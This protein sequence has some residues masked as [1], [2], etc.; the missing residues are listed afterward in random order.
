MTWIQIRLNV[1]VVT[2]VMISSPSSLRAQD[3]LQ[4]QKDACAKNTAMTWNSEMNRCVGK[5]QTRSERHEAQDC[6]KLEDVNAR[7]ACHMDV[8]TKKAGVTSDPEQAGSKVSSLQ[9]RSAMINT[10][11]TIVSL[12]NMFASKKAGSACMS[13]SIMGITAM[14]GLAT[15]IY[16]KI[17]TKKKLGALKD[18]FQ[19]ELKDSAYN[20]QVKALAFLKEEQEVVQKIA[21]MEK[22][23]QMLLML[24]YGAAA[25]AAGYESFTNADC[26]KKEPDKAPAPP[27]EGA[28]TVAETATPGASGAAPADPLAPATTEG[29]AETFAVA[30]RGPVEARELPPLEPSVATTA[31]PSPTPGTSVAPATPVKQFDSIESVKD[32]SYMR[33]IAKDSTGKVTGVVHNG[34]M[35]TDFKQNASGQYMAM[36]KPQGAFDYNTGTYQGQQFSQVAVTSNYVSINGKISASTTG[37][38][39]NLSKVHYGTNIKVKK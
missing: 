14:G 5:V 30:D 16:F 33:T 19:L 15:D 12:L 13:K 8:A 6:N 9:S 17:Q 2:S 25:V 34:Q 21:S 4:A 36:G 23:R 11:T 7:K 38:T 37:G 32:G 27:K 26:W 24:G 1:I 18:K 35:Y 22:K 29:G 39:A 20:A 10:A 31:P 3:E 28:E